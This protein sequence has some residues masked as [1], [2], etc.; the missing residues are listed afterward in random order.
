MRGRNILL[1]IFLAIGV[2]S[3]YVGTRKA[4]EGIRAKSWPTAKGRIVTSKVDEIRTE[5]KMRIARL[6]LKVDY[7][8]MVDNVI[9]E[10]HRVNVG[11]SC[12]GTQA[13]VEE[14]L[15]RYPPGAEVTVYYNPAYP[16]Q[17]LL[18]PGLDWSIFLLWGIASMSFGI[19][20]PLLKARRR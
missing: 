18:E 3:F 11:W 19:A 12:F 5:Q 8:Y 1:Y 9:Y 4:V 15:K 2:L 14:K 17:A 6:C 7:L 20:W 16:S 10:G 13:S